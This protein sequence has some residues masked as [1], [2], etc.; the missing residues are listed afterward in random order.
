MTRYSTSRG[1][2]YTAPPKTDRRTADDDQPTATADDKPTAT[3]ELAPT[4]APA[5]D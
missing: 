3:A 5:D 2:L 1:L 4:A